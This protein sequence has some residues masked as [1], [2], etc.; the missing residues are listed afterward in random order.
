[1]HNYMPNLKHILQP[2]NCLFVLFKNIILFKVRYACRYEYAATAID[3][4][5]RRLRLAF[6]NVSAA[7]EALP[8]IVDIM[9][10]ELGWSL[11]EKRRQTEDAIQFLKDQ[12]GKD[13]NKKSRESMPISLNKAEIKLYVKRFNNM[14]VERKGFISMNDIRESLK[15]SFF[16]QSLRGFSLRNFIHENLCFTR[17]PH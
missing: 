4:I 3:V 14:D 13:V 15:V 10:E 16:L 6:I 7:E 17:I 12:M 2:N 5:A 9:G 8:G 11:A 1:M